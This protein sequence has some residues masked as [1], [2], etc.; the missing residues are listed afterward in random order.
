MSKISTDLQKFMSKVKD[1]EKGHEMDLAS[2]E[3]LSMVVMNLIAIEEHMFFNANKTGKTKYF[4]LLNEA[5]E[6]RKVLMKMLIPD[7]EGEVWCTSKHLLAASMRVMEVGTKYQ[8]KGDTKTAYDLFKKSYDLFNLFWTIN[9][10]LNSNSSP[11]SKGETAVGREGFNPKE[12]PLELK[13]TDIL[14][15]LSGAIDKILDCCR[16]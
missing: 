16:E 13:K 6:M 11:L 9:L 7:Y 3:D 4:E 1:A 10:G 5:R 14:G 15:K 12:A 8:T 2:G